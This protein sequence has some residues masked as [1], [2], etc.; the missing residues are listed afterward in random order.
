MDVFATLIEVVAYDPTLGSLT[1]H[2]LTNRNDPRATTANG[3][4]WA[5]VVSQSP[6]I[7]CSVFNGAFTAAGQIDLGDFVISL[8]DTQAD[9][10]TRLVWSG[11][12][13]K[14]F[15]GNIAQGVFNQLFTAVGTGALRKG[16]L[17]LVVSMTD[18]SALLDQ[19]MLAQ[20]YAGT[21]NL[22]GSADVKGVLKPWVFGDAKFCRPVL[23][24]PV[25]QIYQVSAYG[26][27][28]STYAVFEGGQAIT[29]HADF[30]QAQ[31]TDFLTGA[32]PPLGKFSRLNG[33]GL[34]RL[35]SRPS[36]PVTCH[37]KGDSGT[38]VGGTA[39]T[40]VGNVI[41]RILGVTTALPV[42]ATSL[43]NLNALQVEPV[44]ECFDEQLTIADALAGLLLG[45]GAYHTFNELGELI[46]GRVRFGSTTLNL[47]GTNSLEPTVL[48]INQLPTSAPVWDLR[49]G[50]EQCHFVHQTSDVPAAL[51]QA[52][53]DAAA[54]LLAAGNAQTTANGKNKVFGPSTT[55]PVGAVDGDLWPD[56]SVTPQ[57]T[58]RY[59]GQSA[60]WVA[61]SNQV[62]NTNQVADG[63]G[64]GLTA[65]WDSVTGQGKL[66]LIQKANDAFTNANTAQ[67][68]ANTAL[69]QIDAI[70]ADGVLSRGE[71]PDI[72]RQYTDANNEYADIIAKANG[73]SVTT[74]VYTAAYNALV[75]YVGTLNPALTDTANNTNI[76]ITNFNTTFSNYYRD[77]QAILNAIAAKAATLATWD[78]V[79]GQGKI[80]LI[81]QS[82]QAATNAT[83]AINAIN[84]LS[85]D[86]I[87]SRSEKLAFLTAMN[88]LNR[89]YE[90]AASTSNQLNSVYGG[91]PTG[92]GRANMFNGRQDLNNYLGGIG[93]WADPSQ[94]SFIN[95]VTL[96]SLVNTVYV[97]ISELL[98]DNASYI[99]SKANL[100]VVNAAAALAD[101]SNIGADNVLHKSEKPELISRWNEVNAAYNGA[102]TA[103]TNI[104]ATY[105]T[106]YTATERNAAYSAYQAAADYLTAIPGGWSTTTTDSTINGATLRTMFQNVY[107]AIANLERANNTV[108]VQRAKAA[109]DQADSAQTNAGTALTQIVA[110]QADNVLSAGEKPEIIRRANDINNELAGIVAQAAAFGI[111]S[112]AY[113]TSQSSLNTYLGGIP[114]GWNDTSQN[115]T[116]VAST[117][118]GMWANYYSARQALLNAIAAKAAT[119]ATWDGTTGIGKPE[120]FA[121][122]GNN[123]VYN[124]DAEQGTTTGI[125]EAFEYAGGTVST[126]ITG[127]AEA[128]KG[129]YAFS[130]NKT[131]NAGGFANAWRGVPL[132]V[133]R[134]YI[135]RVSMYASE[136]TPNGV[137]VRMRL[138]DSLDGNGFTDSQVVNLFFHE[139]QPGTLGLTVLEFKFTAIRKF[140][141]PAVYNWTNG[142]LRLIV[143]EVEVKEANPW[144]GITGDGRPAD[145]ASADT[146]MIPNS[147]ARVVGNA[148]YARDNAGDW[149]VYAATNRFARTPCRVRGKMP[150]GG[151]MVGLSKFATAQPGPTYGQC[152]GWHR[153]TDTDWY[154]GNS[155]TFFN[156]GKAKAG[157]TFSDNT[158]FEVVWNGIDRIE[159]YADDVFIDY[160]PN[161]LNVAGGEGF[162]GAVAAVATTPNRVTDLAFTFNA[163]ITALNQHS[164]GDVG[165]VQLNADYQGIIPA[166]Q[167]P[168]VRSFRRL[169]G[170]TDV[171]PQTA[172]AKGFTPGLTATINN[173]IGTNS[174]GDLTITGYQGGSTSVTVS[175]TYA[176]VTLYK[177]LAITVTLA[178]PPASGGSA[179]TGGSTGGSG[180]GSP[181]STSALTG[182][183]SSTGYIVVATLAPVTIGTNA[184]CELA[185]SITYSQAT[186]TTEGDT[187]SLVYQW[188]V[189][190]NGGGWVDVGPQQFGTGA[191]NYYSQDPPKGARTGPGYATGITTHTSFNGAQAT[192]R[193]LGATTNTALS[194]FSGTISAT[195]K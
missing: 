71:K 107:T 106:D 74:S 2:R 29:F 152:V 50:A 161:S 182:P 51:A 140:G 155:G 68:N 124:G 58:R 47:D 169:I 165:D 159:F 43:S 123:L 5:P 80:D 61:T 8:A 186:R 151:T 24:D 34:I 22:E 78:G 146:V 63:A 7:G 27:I 77:R 126:T 89:S 167:F 190:I 55:P 135:L 120:S 57:T 46:F 188:Q 49:L 86:N 154:I 97:R 28:E 31:L 25:R 177:Q 4:S 158:M 94:D 14:V 143:D 130:M 179:G 37:V 121:T 144:L 180:A 149:S 56:I 166:S 88:D 72:I 105:G 6:T 93:N 99:N 133:G 193:L 192:Y 76:N 185:S 3:Q 38:V 125:I 17:E 30:S 147:K 39:I 114:N 64:L 18:R 148:V 157:V 42:K 20:S 91:D 67:G 45:F 176:G 195:P 110:I 101:L 21:G 183:G 116:I 111:S 75:T 70:Q 118:N 178:P 65:V 168:I 132:Q 172:Y 92:S 11:A 109:K 119:L 15:A 134:E 174:R 16:R 59:N 53:T 35:G 66:D 103:S 62:T 33:Y 81:N 170:I 12:Q 69:T 79:S 40:K 1:T 102:V 84:D 13:I 82:A 83:N 131:A 108:S 156:Q 173:D 23:L 19:N 171:S 117:F 136:A 127:S 113:T 162:Y 191:F 138:G 153:S 73:V 95:G 187:T 141:C 32:S 142:P 48:G 122:R 189:S 181:S 139:N 150:I 52:G 128:V 164:T 26:P 194:G 184:T 60:T 10:L 41:N 115:S 87:L 160:V 137:Y 90:S 44:D 54:A 163:D 96:R 129:Q 36:F 112:S 145:N 175:E 85:S 98:A 9:N 100:G 104:T